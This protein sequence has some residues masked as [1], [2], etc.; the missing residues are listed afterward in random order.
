MRIS[1]SDDFELDKIIY[2]G[3]CFRPCV[4]GENKD[5]RQVYRFITGEH[6]LY[7]SRSCTEN[8]YDVTCFHTN[9]T[10]ERKE[11]VIETVCD[12]SEWDNI[13]SDYFDLKRDYR[14]IRNKISSKD[15]YMYECACDGMGV[16]ILKQDKWEM[17]ISFI[18][19]QRKSI[20]AIRSC[21]E[22]LCERYGSKIKTDR[23][24]V[25]LFPT[26]GQL[27]GASEKELADCGLGYR[28]GYIIDATSR[29]YYKDTDLDALEGLDDDELFDELLKIKG[30]GKKVTNCI[31]LFAYNRTGRAPVDVWIARVID[32]FYEGND[33]FPAYRENAG[34]MQQYVFYHIQNR[35]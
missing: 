31:M 25:Y 7:I 11:E 20:G 24:E 6:V 28:V 15:S 1:V 21:V 4:I 29:V 9:R 3:Q 27:I 30:V 26:P 22:K 12:D 16:R 2:S 19:S 18:I 13:W 10:E 32:E 23:E 35:N 34:I 14:S 33:P 5:N 8:E 17:L